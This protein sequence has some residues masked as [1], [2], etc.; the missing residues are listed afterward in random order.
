MRNQTNDVLL[1]NAFLDA[2]TYVISRM[3]DE[4][5]LNIESD[6]I[7]FNAL[8]KYAEKRNCNA[9]VETCFE[10]DGRAI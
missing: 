2:D 4:E 7:L 9:N 6:L 1:D 8:N 5:S 3:F 10:P